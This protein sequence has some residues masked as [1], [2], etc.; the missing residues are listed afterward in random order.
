MTSPDY[1]PDYFRKDFIIEK[2]NAYGFDYSMK[3]DFKRL[4]IWAVYSLGYVNRTDEWQEYVPHF[5]RRHNVNLLVSYVLGGKLDWEVNFRWNYGSG[6]PFTE[7]AGYYEKLSFSDINQNIPNSNGQLGVLYGDINSRRL[8]DYHRLD[9]S[10]KK[11]F[12]VGRNSTLETNLSVTNV[13]N[14]ENLFYF[15]TIRN[16]RVNQLPFMPSLGMSLSF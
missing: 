9:I 8:P 6:F 2:G 5:D 11:K 12:F 15:N 7:T 4:Y 13:Y 16:E 10:L 3:Y 14:R 1:K